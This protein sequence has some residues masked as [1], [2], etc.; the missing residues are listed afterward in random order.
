MILAVLNIQ[1]FIKHVEVDENVLERGTL[2]VPVPRSLANAAF[3][4]PP[5]SAETKCIMFHLLRYDMENHI[6]YFDFN[7]WV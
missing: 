2:I 6:A 4:E 1:G 3:G 5:L 7:K